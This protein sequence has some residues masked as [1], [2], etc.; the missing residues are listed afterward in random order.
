M[1]QLLRRGTRSFGVLAVVVTAGLVFTACNPAAEDQDFALVNSLRANNGLPA[2]SRSG[3]LNNKARA[4]ADRMAN[5]N[6]IFHSS[7]L[8]S[9][10]SAGWRI[11]GENVAVAGS[12]EQAQQ[13]LE[14][15]PGHLEN[16]LNG[17]FTEMGVGVTVKNGRVY[18][19]QVF[20]GR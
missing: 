20:V 4:H 6:R 11:I 15:S 2:L 13:A 7:N 10:V 19:V 9:G 14:A 16:M 17:E 1:V 3:E 8:A 18:V 12:I 5:R